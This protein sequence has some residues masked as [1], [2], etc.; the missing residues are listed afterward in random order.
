M[1]G[2]GGHQPDRGEGNSDGGVKGGGGRGGGRGVM[3]GGERNTLGP[4]HQNRLQ[5]ATLTN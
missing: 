4:G 5:V 3:E 2:S 1:V